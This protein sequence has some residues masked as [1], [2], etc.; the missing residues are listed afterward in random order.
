MKKNKI[1]KYIVFGLLISS[2]KYLIDIPETLSCFMTGMG[3]TLL[4][5]GFGVMA[6]DISKFK[7]WKR[8]LFKK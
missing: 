7:T 2:V 3:I 8:N 5:F 4:I 1:N 6:H